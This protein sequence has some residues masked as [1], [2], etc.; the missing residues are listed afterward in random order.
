MS[1][2]VVLGMRAIIEA[3]PTRI[4]SGGEVFL[5]LFL[6][7]VA[8]PPLKPEMPD[9]G[10]PMPSVTFAA[11]LM[12]RLVKPPAIVLFHY[13][14]PGN[15]HDEPVYNI[16]V[17]WPDD[18]PIIRAQDL[19]PA[20]NQELFAYYAQR[21]PAR[22]VYRFDR[23]TGKLFLLGNVVELAHRPVTTSTPTTPTTQP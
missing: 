13:D 18:A 1:L 8:L 14:S 19:G 22:T 2:M 4:R 6:A 20:R 3:I 12:P 10:Y 11:K 21:Q 16:D 9:D 23:A 15:F 7:G 5:V 17:A